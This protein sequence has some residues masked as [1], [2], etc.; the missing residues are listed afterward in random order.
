MNY[1]NGTHQE[2]I[3]FVVDDNPVNLKVLFTLLK[4]SGFKVLVATNGTDALQKLQNVKPHL[5]LLDVSMPNI[6]GFELCKRL[7]ASEKTADIPVVFLTALSDLEH[8]LEGL[9]LGAVD[10]ICKPFQKQE[11]LSRICLHLKLSQLQQALH[12]QNQKLRNAV[13][14]KESAEAELVKLNNQLEQKVSDRT[15]ELSEAVTQLATQQAQLDYKAN[16]DVLTELPN[17]AFF[18]E[19][20][21]KILKQSDRDWT[22]LWLDLDNFKKINDS[23]GHIVGD[24]LLQRVAQRLQSV[25]GE[26]GIIARLGGDEFAI[27]H[28][29][30]ESNCDF[31]ELA[32]TLINKLQRPFTLQHYIITVNASIGTIASIANYSDSTEL[33]RD[34]DFALYQAKSLGKGQYAILTPQLKIQSLERIQIETDLSRGMDRNEFCLHY[35]P[36]FSLK[37]K[38]LVGFEALIR[39]QHP[40]KGLLMPNRFIPIAEE[41]GMVE[42]LDL[43]TLKTACDRLR[44]WKQEFGIDDTF[45]VSVNYSSV[46]LQSLER[47]ASLD[48]SEYLQDLAPENLKIEITESGF[49]EA[50]VAG[51][52]VLKSLVDRRI[53]LCID[54]FG[55]GFSSLSRLHSFPAQILKIDR[56]F[57]KR[58]D[59]GMGGLAVVQTITNLAQDLGMDIIAEGI[60][61]QEQL[62]FLENLM[63]NFGQGYLFSKPL[64]VTEATHL[65]SNYFPAEQNLHYA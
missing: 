56:S 42:K 59:V 57:V 51:M 11:V 16:H 54:D 33:L 44:L 26:E 49:W 58:L 3:I 18:M 36:I 20:L 45:S 52:D 27:L 43:W 28:P 30:E 21:Q 39:W 37:T 32:Q 65:L 23:F 25:L 1:I 13:V 63:C 38:N 47:L 48:W 15:Q 17:R 62:T 31:G 8:K 2:N 41:T 60:E 53:K 7:K 46:T 50:S 6:S 14:E 24:R 55:T 9:S 4:E 40:K 35:Q 34:A 5:I 10:F 12:Q 29:H 61:T 64:S 19:R 22:L